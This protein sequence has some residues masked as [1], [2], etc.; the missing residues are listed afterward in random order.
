VPRISVILPAHNAARTIARAVDSIL[1]QT[2]ADFELVIVDDGSTDDTA[3]V[4]SRF[5]DPR[6][7]VLFHEHC[8]LV[9][10]LN[11]GIT[12]SSGTYVARMDADD[13]ALPDRFVKQTDFLD[14]HQ[15]VA[16]LGSGVNVIYA[17]GTT[18]TRRRP[19]DTRSIKR[20]IVRINP[21]SHS[22]VL[23]RR[24]ALDNVGLYDATKDGSKTLLVEDLDLWVRMLAAGYDM[25]NL[26]DVLMHYYREPDSILR[27]KSLANR[28]R[29]Q[30]LSRVDIIH[31]LRLGF[32]AYLN[33]PPVIVA[34]VLSHYG[35]RLDGI[36]N[37]LS[38]PE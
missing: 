38:P 7:R 10:S 33:V 11:R 31:K 17:D 22:S 15:K 2:F 1:H 36:F 18:R 24:S 25:A 30:V 32:T 34:S 19:A 20:N 23:M 35:V 37:F 16:V 13:F 28:L 5:A 4:L 12:E 29:Q 14:K 21:F 6:I 8:G 9:P 3:V 26:P 27:S